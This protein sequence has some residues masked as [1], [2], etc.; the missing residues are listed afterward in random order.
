MSGDAL[1][2]LEDITVDLD[3]F[4]RFECFVVSFICFRSAEDRIQS[5]GLWKEEV[6]VEFA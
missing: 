6:F 2:T 1:Q 4:D 3:F 5:L